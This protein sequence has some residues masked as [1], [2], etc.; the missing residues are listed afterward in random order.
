MDNGGGTDTSPPSTF[1]IS[2]GFINSP[3]TFTL[4]SNQV[5]AVFSGVQTVPG[6]VTNIVAGPSNGP[7][8]T[9]SFFVSNSDNQLF[10]VQP[11]ISAN[12][13]LTYE[14]S[15]F[16][17]TAT[18]SVYAM[19]NGGTAN[20]GFDTSAIETFTITVS[21]LITAGSANS[22]WVADVYTVLLGRAARPDE[23]AYWVTQMANGPRAWK[24][25]SRLR[26]ATS[27]TPIMSPICSTRIWA[28]RRTRTASLTSSA[29]STRERRPIRSRPKS[30][31][32][33]R[34]TS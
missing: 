6:F 16:L 12:G 3:P 14:P 28:R 4:G 24:W 27:T 26:A 2:V 32:R 21:P 9:T 8:L 13:T 10:T 22:L 20:G 5:V 29:S 34:F 25:P 17:G 15:S 23:I 33:R 30:C 31:R 18:V 1:V 7:A 19:N 11:S